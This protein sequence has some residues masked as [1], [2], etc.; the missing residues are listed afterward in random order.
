[1]L[2]ATK[3][4]YFSSCNLLKLKAEL[5]PRITMPHASCCMLR[6]V[7]LTVEKETKKEHM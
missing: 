7:S 2:L 6:V 4:Y 3:M 1:M 5:Q